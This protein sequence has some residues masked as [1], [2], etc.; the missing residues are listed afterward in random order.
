MGE[1]E[2]RQPQ[3]LRVR[4]PK[5]NPNFAID[6]PGQPEQDICHFCTIFLSYNMKVRRWVISRSISSFKITTESSSECF[7]CI[8]VYFCG[9]SKAPLPMKNNCMFLARDRR[10]DTLLQ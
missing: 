8:R 3:T 9:T 6:L 4:R 2:E 1:R 5:A 7:A 10:N